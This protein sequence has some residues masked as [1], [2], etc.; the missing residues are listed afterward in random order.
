MPCQGGP[1]N[2][3]LA[4]AQRMAND[5]EFCK[6]QREI[7]RQAKIER[8]KNYKKRLKEEKQILENELNNHTLENIAFNSFMTVF[9]CRLMQ[10]VISNFGY[11]FLPEEFEW[12][13]HE[14]G[15]R[16]THNDTT[17]KNKEELAK[18][19]IEIAK[20]YKVC[21]HDS[22][23]S[24]ISI[25]SIKTENDPDKNLGDIDILNNIE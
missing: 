9:V 20:E 11:K 6:Q 2:E 8:E 4:F 19:L 16:D 7:W 15:W 1:T 5:P 23:E 22:T 14:H 24:L 12:W 10:I 17:L 18:K 25:Y 13:W 3:E 21:K